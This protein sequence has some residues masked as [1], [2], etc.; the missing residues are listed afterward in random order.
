[1]KW[2]LDE[3]LPPDAAVE[4]QRLGHDACSVRDVGLGGAS[5]DIVY[6]YAVSEQRAVVTENFG[7]FARLVEQRQARDEPSVPVVFVRK[8]DLRRGG[9]LA[10]HL[11]RHLHDWAMSNPEPYPGVHWP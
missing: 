2:L 3:M 11:A 8:R 1:V 7:D 10:G 4:L 5:D 9:A 6:D